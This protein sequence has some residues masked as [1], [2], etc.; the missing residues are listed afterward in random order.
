VNVVDIT[1]V[2][3]SHPAFCL[4]SPIYKFPVIVGR[5]ALTGNK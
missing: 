5:V 1:E 3:Q 4:V 2:E